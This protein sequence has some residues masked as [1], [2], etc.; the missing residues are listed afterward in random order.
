M[1]EDLGFKDFYGLEDNR[2]WKPCVA[3]WPRRSWTSGKL[4]WLRPM[5]HGTSKYYGSRYIAISHYWLTPEEYTVY[6]ISR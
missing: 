5:V 2:V 3:W 6:L 1:F 4:H